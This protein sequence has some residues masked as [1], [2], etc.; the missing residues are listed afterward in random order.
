MDYDVDIRIDETALDVEW[1]EQPS[2]MMKYARNAAEARKTLDEA[3]EALDVVKAQLDKAIREK[4][5]K[6]NIDKITESVVSNTILLE[7]K[8]Q[9]S[10]K[11]VLEAKYE[12]DMAQAA[13][14]AFDARKDA[15]ENLRSLLGMQYFAGPREPRDISHEAQIKHDQKKSDKTVGSKLHRNK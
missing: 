13:V 4:P 2:L 14:R 6:Y 3:K 10:N 7:P 1:L 12:L 8:Y 9:V 5:D 11:K 15:L